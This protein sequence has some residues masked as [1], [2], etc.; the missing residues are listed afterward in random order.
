MNISVGLPPM[1]LM[2]ANHYPY[3]VVHERVKLTI[4][5]RGNYRD[6]DKAFFADNPLGREEFD[7]FDD[8]TQVLFPS[9]I[10]KVLLATK[11]YPALQPNEVFVPVA[12]IFKEETL[13]I[14]GTVFEMLDRSVLDEREA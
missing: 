10:T 14:I 6:I 2:A 12:I 7:I 13:D 9:Q 11:Q 8:E 3:K 4:P 1:L 5:R